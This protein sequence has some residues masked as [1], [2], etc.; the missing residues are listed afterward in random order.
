VFPL[1]PDITTSIVANRMT[2]LRVV[3]SDRDYSADLLTAQDKIL[4]ESFR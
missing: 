4:N 1:K 3:S 2:P